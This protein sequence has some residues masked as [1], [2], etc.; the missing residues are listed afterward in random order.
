MYDRFTERAKR[1]MQLANQEAQRFNHEYIGTEHI[2]LGLI[3]EGTGVASQALRNMDVDLRKARLSIEELVQSGPEMVTMGR[4]PQTHGA[5]KVLEYAEEERCNLDH[6]FLGTEH[7]ILGLL[8]E[9]EGTA[10][11]VLMN[12]GLKL[13]LVRE[14]V[15]SL[16]GMGVSTPEE[17]AE[18]TEPVTTMQ[19]ARDLVDQQRHFPRR[20]PL[21]ART[22]RKILVA[23]NTAGRNNVFLTG[24]RHMVDEY[25]SHIAGLLA[26]C[27]G[28]ESMSTKM[29]FQLEGRGMGKFGDVCRE[30][31]FFGNMILY[32]EL[33]SSSGMGDGGR[34]HGKWRR[35]RSRSSRFVKRGR[36]WL[37]SGSIRFVFSGTKKQWFRFCK[38]SPRIADGFTMVALPEADAVATSTIVQLASEELAFTHLVEFP[39]PVVALAIELTESSFGGSFSKPHR[40]IRVLDYAAAHKRLFMKKEDSAEQAELREKAMTLGG[41]LK[42]ALQK[43]RF[44]QAVK[45]R[46]EIQKIKDSLLKSDQALPSVT[47]EDIRLAIEDLTH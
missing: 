31:E 32:K 34:S 4:L 21:D 27:E 20:V 37:D 22:I 17:A 2:L 28:P 36:G 15:M 12:H 23:L 8:R 44:S 46:A 10:A 3:K 45:T 26:E 7:L 6:N 19:V 35:H 43:G 18:P 9:N 5:K 13:N 38:H 1:V 29:F 11:Q 39:E 24:D 25:V 42:S 30:A 16:L 47:E 33:F 40:A 41:Q 14:E